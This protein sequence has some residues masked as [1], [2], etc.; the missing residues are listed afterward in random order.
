MECSVLVEI[1]GGTAIPIS[2]PTSKQKT[3]MDYETETRTIRLTSEIIKCIAKR[4][5]ASAEE[6]ERSLWH[7][8]SSSSERPHP[9]PSEHDDGDALSL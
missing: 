1:A 2:P 4:L 8:S 7:Y 5:L 6:L 9:T 3:E